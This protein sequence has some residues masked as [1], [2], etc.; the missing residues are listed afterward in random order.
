MGI[1]VKIESPHGADGNMLH[2]P[3]DFVG[4]LLATVNLDATRCLGFIDPY[5][6]TV[7]NQLQIPVLIDE[8]K[9]AVASVSANNLRS[10]RE[11]GLRAARGANWDAAVVKE[12]ETRAS[13]NEFEIRSELAKMKV[14]L[15]QVLDVLQKAANAGPH[16]FVRFIGD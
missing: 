15:E 2:D 3:Q 9:A 4:L 5:G 13:A 7:F 11:K 6:D 14:H 12:Y 16:H 1:D 10:H 8:F